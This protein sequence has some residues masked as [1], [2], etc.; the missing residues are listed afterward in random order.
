MDGDG[1]RCPRRPCSGGGCGCR[2]G[3]G[4]GDGAG[5]EDDQPQ[6][7]GDEAGEDNDEAALQRAEREGFAA[8]PPGKQPCTECL[9]RSVKKGGHASGY[10][11][12]SGIEPHYTIVHATIMRL[13]KKRLRCSTCKNWFQ[14]KAARKEH[15][16][17]VGHK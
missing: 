11:N 7:G 2:R 12:T 13:W 9:R 10:F 8:A 4:L 3:A 6:Q 1:W 17:L 14:T 15:Q 5:A 16:R